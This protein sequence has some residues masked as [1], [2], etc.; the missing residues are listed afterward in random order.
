MLFSI[1]VVVILFLLVATKQCVETTSA[2]LAYTFG[3]IYVNSGMYIEHEAWQSFLV[4]AMIFIPFGY[5]VKVPLGIALMSY[6]FFNISLSL[7]CANNP[8][9]HYVYSLYSNVHGLFAVFLVCTALYQRAGD[10][11]RIHNVYDPLLECR[12][13]DIISGKTFYFSKMQNNE[14]FE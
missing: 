10:N 11:E 6:V 2:F 9:D 12:I 8:Y 3:F 14:G 7:W 5:L 1:V 13:C 4:L